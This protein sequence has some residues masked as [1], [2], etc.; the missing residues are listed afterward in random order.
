M[1]RPLNIVALHISIPVLDMEAAVGFYTEIFGLKVISK[2]DP[3]TQLYFDNHRISL[4]KTKAD[5][6]SLQKDAFTGIRSRHFGFRVESREEIDRINKQLQEKGID[7]IAGPQ[8]RD[9]GR[10][11]FCADPSGNQIEIYFEV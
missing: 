5:S 3:L 11:L 8:D 7:V 2:S 1:N 4:K 9:D 10:T 6:S